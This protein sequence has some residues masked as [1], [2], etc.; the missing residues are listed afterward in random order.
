M[1]KPTSLPDQ[2]FNAAPQGQEHL[3]TRIAADRPNTTDPT[4]RFNLAG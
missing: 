2:A 1:A 4:D 3:P